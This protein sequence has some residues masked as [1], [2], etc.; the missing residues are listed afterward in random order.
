MGDPAAHDPAPVPDTRFEVLGPLTV[1]HNGTELPIPPA[2]PQV[3]LATLLLHAGELLSAERLTDLIW[4]GEPPATSRTALH[5]YVMRLRHAL[6]PCLSS[7]VRTQSSSYL[8]EVGQG[9]LDLHEFTELRERGRDELRRAD[10]DR[11][12]A[13]LRQALA[14]WTGEPLTGLAAPAL[15]SVELPGLMESALQALEWRIESDLRRGLHADLVA[16]LLTLT[17]A[18]PLRERFHAQLILALYRSGNRP[19]ALGAFAAARRVIVAEL[20]VEPG[21]ELQ[22]LHARIL[23]TPEPGPAPQPAPAPAHAPQP[24]DAPDAPGALEPPA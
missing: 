14:L 18:H 6:G 17:A 13:T 5:N 16:E 21:R 24:P 11:S 12:A 10:W 1:R 3:L 2:K 9:E 23:A 22:D 8:I 20:G 15:R 7:R 19:G 4:D